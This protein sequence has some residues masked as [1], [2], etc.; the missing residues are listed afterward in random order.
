MKKMRYEAYR[1]R[2]DLEQAAT[3]K[4]IRISERK[5]E[6]IKQKKVELASKSQAI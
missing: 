3:E 2:L 5:L 6:N 4:E 1:N